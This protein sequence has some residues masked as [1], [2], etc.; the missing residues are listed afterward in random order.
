MYIQTFL[1]NNIYTI[2]LWLYFGMTM[3]ASARNNSVIL[4]F[5]P[6][7]IATHSLNEGCSHLHNDNSLYQIKKFQFN[8]KTEENEKEK[9]SGF[10][11]SIF[12]KFFIG[13]SSNEG[14]IP[15]IQ[16][17]T[18]LEQPFEAIFNCNCDNKYCDRIK[19]SFEK[20]PGYFTRALD[21]YKPIKVRFN[22]FSF[23]QSEER[24]NSDALAIT[25]PP[26]Y[27]I[28]KDSEN[29][30]PFSYPLTL[31]KQLNT[32]IEIQFAP[33]DEDYDIDI[34]INTD[35]ML[36]DQYFTS[37][38]AH[39]ILHGMGIYYLIQPLSTMLPNLGFS[40][41]VVMPPVDTAEYENNDGILKEIKT[42]LPPSIYEKNF[43]DLQKLVNDNLNLSNNN[44]LV[45]SDY[46]F[47]NESYYWAF[48]DLPLN[49]YVHQP[50][51]ED[52]EI[53]QLQQFNQTL[54]NWRGYP[55][56]QDFFKSASSANSIGFLTTEGDIV[57]LQTYD[58]EYSGDFFH[59][60]TPY[61]CESKFKCTIEDETD[62]H[63]LEFGPNFVMLP[64]YYAFDMT[65]EEKINTFAPHNQYGLLGDGVV[66]MLTTM[67]WTER[68]HTR[69]DKNYIILM[70]EDLQNLQILDP[71]NPST[72]ELNINDEQDIQALVSGA[73][74]S[75]Y[76]ASSKFIILSVI[77]TLLF[78]M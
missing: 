57:K 2:L 56:A 40:S 75:F 38:L 24:K 27:L 7:E 9:D 23:S 76:Y 47:F 71:V 5:V 68:N 17:V 55:I 16:N 62:H 59:I 35:Q 69:N 66:H 33:D 52:S 49:M 30:W 12:A 21:I 29:G 77:F 43:I 10:F 54:F 25:T 46:Y 53:M 4:G 48:K 70:P 1:T 31:I 44:T 15:P 37:M 13:Q 28:L 65:V 19:S 11:S 58:N 61:S 36:E 20:V 64:K 8:V 14:N 34:D 6:S 45:A 67:G 50:N 39:E 60:S 32:N 51:L 41:E 22:V 3:I 26:P 78:L 18:A 42:F 74:T 63:K 72:V 73:N